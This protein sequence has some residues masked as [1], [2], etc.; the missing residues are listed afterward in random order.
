MVASATVFGLPAGA[1]SGEMEGEKVRYAITH[2]DEVEIKSG[3]FLQ[4]GQGAGAQ[5]LAVTGHQPVLPPVLR[6]PSG[7][8]CPLR[9]RAMAHLPVC[10]HAPGEE[11]PRQ[12]NN[13]RALWR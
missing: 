13:W 10:S 7:S 12:P 6:H 3:G 8:S 4:P 2:F 1:F 5:K 9:V 11:N